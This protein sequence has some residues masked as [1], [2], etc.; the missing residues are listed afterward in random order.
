[1][2]DKRFLDRYSNLKPN[3]WDSQS[4]NPLTFM[5]AFYFSCVFNNAW[6]EVVYN[7]VFKQKYLTNGG[8][9]RTMEY[10]DN[11]SWSIDEKLSALAFF[12]YKNDREWVK[13]IPFFP[14]RRNTSF[15][16]WF[17]PDVIAYH[18]YVR[19]GF[20]WWLVDLK[21][22]KSIKEFRRDPLG[23]SSGAQLAFIKLMGAKKD[24]LKYYQH[25]ELVF[26]IY[27]PELEHPTRKVWK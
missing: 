17:R 7:F 3:S 2:I 1:M 18:T 21:I 20:G 13:K 24:P 23:E 25:W 27:Y 11:P 4:E 5:A 15:W 8:E 16:S 26:N 12:N 10:D 19:F 9:W 14:S 6:G 22:R